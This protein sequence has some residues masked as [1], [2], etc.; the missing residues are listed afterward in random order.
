VKRDQ[1]KHVLIDANVLA[2]YIEPKT[3][4]N[5]KV[6]ELSRDL[7]SSVLEYEWPIV[8]L[9]TPTICIAETQCVL[10]KHRHCHWH[11]PAKKREYRLTKKEYL[12]G[13]SALESLIDSRRL[14]RL[15]MSHDHLLA[16]SL[17]SVVNARYQYRRSSGKAKKGKADKSRIKPPMGTA[18]CLIAGMA[19]DLAIRIGSENVVMF[20]ADK[21]L[22]DVIQACSTLSNERARLLGL[23]ELATRLNTKWS[24]SLYPEAVY[25][26]KASEADLVRAFGGWPLP[27]RKIRTKEK[28]S[29][30]VNE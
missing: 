11:G 9:Y 21:R 20:M 6:H 13:L 27:A 18:D 15:D 16:S 23:N 29:L 30:T 25:L 1:R 5:P 28:A 4:R 3:H 17:V 8:Q 7:L 10:D 26:P 22:Y 19:I 14:M 2:A 24:K 12:D